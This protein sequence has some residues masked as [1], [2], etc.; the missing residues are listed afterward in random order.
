MAA[1]C[2]RMGSLTTLLWL[3]ITMV[4]R[5]VA[6]NAGQCGSL[7]VFGSPVLANAIQASLTLS[8]SAMASAPPPVRREV[9]FTLSKTKGIS[10]VCGDF[11][12]PPATGVS[13]VK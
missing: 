1:R 13:H 3:L 4:D 8:A 5:L 6:L 7:G 11:R 10:I 12:R 2:S 9:I